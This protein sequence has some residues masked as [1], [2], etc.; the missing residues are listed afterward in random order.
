MN[1]K[2]VLSIIITLL[3]IGGSIYYVQEIKQEKIT[4]TGKKVETPTINSGINNDQTDNGQEVEIPDEF[5]QCLKENGV[6]V[7]GSST[8][9]ACSRL[10]Q[11]YGGYDKIK[12]IYLDCSGLG[13]EEETERC[14][15]EMQTSYIPE[16]QIKG[17]LFEG[18]GSPEALAEVIGCQLL[19]EE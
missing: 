16:V 10:E 19:K 2:I 6:V 3:L 8:C 9:P 13:T 7:Y 18:W 17:E 15:E 14:K 1:K 12:P 5:I 11:E 4:E